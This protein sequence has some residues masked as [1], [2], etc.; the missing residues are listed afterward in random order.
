M[1]V[2]RKK[3]S[4]YLDE[5]LVQ[6]AKL[7]AATS[8]KHDYEIVEEALREYLMARRA[9]AGRRFAQLFDDIAAYQRATGIRPLTE[10]EATHM[11]V[12]AV[13][14]VRAGRGAGEQRRPEQG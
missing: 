6:S 14:E 2:A 13:R 5:Q 10:D 1:A 12:E 9:E 7:M 11:A 8:G 4:L 3:T